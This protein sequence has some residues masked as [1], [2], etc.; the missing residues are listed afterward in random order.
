MGLVAV[1]ALREGEGDDALPRDEPPL[2]P[3]PMSLLIIVE[4]MVRVHL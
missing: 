2:E 4:S 1:V 3:L